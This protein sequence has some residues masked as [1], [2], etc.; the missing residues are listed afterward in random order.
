MPWS[1]HCQNSPKRKYN[2]VLFT[3]SKRSSH[4]TTPAREST[5]RERRDSKDHREVRERRDS[6]E[7]REVRERKHST[8]KKEIPRTVRTSTQA[9]SSSRPT[10]QPQKNKENKKD[11]IDADCTDNPL[12]VQF[13]KD[14]PVNRPIKK[15]EPKS[16]QKEVLSKTNENKMLPLMKS[17]SV[18]VF[19]SKNISLD[20]NLE[21]QGSKYNFLRSKTTLELKPAKI[22][23]RNE[24]GLP[25]VSPIQKYEITL[26]LIEDILRRGISGKERQ[27]TTAR[28]LCENL[29][30]YTISITAAKRHTLEDVDLYFDNKNDILV[31]VTQKEKKI[32]RKRCL[33]KIQS[34]PGKLD[35]VSV[36]ACNV[37]NRVL[38]PT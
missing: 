25:F 24:D 29:L 26:L 18:G 4:I 11:P 7:H 1:P 13:V 38:V 31:E 5:S 3:D 37:G 14:N 30:R 12:V 21:P 27:C 9:P 22:I 28:L 20:T 6:K 8:S 34:L 35:H 16:S 19:K 10:K 15:P 23:P 32:R 36:V 2:K 17:S 33:E